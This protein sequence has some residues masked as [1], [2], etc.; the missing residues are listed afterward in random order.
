MYLYHGTTL[1]NYI[2]I[3]NEGILYSYNDYSNTNNEP[4]ARKTF[5]SDDVNTAMKYGSYIIKVDA[6]L[7]QYHSISKGEYIIHT[8]I[9]FKRDCELTRAGG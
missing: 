7:Y 4:V 3:E 5:L 1:H 2:K 9:D 8:P 6:S